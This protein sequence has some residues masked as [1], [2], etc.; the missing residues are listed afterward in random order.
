MGKFGFF[1]FKVREHPIVRRSLTSTPH[2]LGNLV[3]PASPL[4]GDSG[5]NYLFQQPDVQLTCFYTSTGHYHANANKTD[6]ASRCRVD[7]ARQGLCQRARHLPV[8]AGRGIFPRPRAGRQHI[9]IA[10]AGRFPERGCTRCRSERRRLQTSSGTK[11]P[12]L[13]RPWK[14]MLETIT[15]L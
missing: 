1:H 8:A 5:S 14:G 3:D 13:K 2:R 11:T 6:L 7:R 10:T 9:G 4:Q 15:V 12:G